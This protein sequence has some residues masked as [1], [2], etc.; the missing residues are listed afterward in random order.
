MKL[1][2]TGL[3]PGVELPLELA[4]ADGVLLEPPPIPPE[5][6]PEDPEDPEEPAEPEVALELLLLPLVLEPDLDAEEDDE[7]AFFFAVLLLLL[8]LAAEASLPEPVPEPPAAP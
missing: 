3:A 5:P 6:V 2:N 7:P 4:E 8:L 1:R